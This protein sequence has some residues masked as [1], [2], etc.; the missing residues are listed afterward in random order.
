MVSAI[1]TGGWLA[2]AHVMVNVR[3]WQAMTHAFHESPAWL[4]RACVVVP[5]F[6]AEKTLGAVVRDLRAQIPELESNIVVVDDGSRDRT[7]AVA[8]EL[9]C[10]LISHGRNRG[11]GAAL[12]TGFATALACNREVA[13]TV[14]ADG[15]H[16][17]GEARRVLLASTH[18]GSLVLGI[19]DLDRAGAPKQNQM[20]NGI[21]NFFLSRFAGV[22]LLDTQCGLRRYPIQRTLALGARGDGF[23]FEGEVLLRAAWDGVPIVEESILVLYPEDRVTHFRVPRDPWRIIRTVVA[24]LGERAMQA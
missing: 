4:A 1:A 21:S 17:G 2:F 6:D 12:R 11:K 5:A 19:R 18:P 24:A 14:D 22:R 8:K 7:A 16:P 13:L 20:S 3:K 23:D 9:G 10:E 15:Q